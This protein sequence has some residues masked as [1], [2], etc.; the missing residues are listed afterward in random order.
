MENKNKTQNT[1]DYIVIG[2][3]TAGSV[4]A[5]KLTDD[6]KTSLLS[7]EAGDN[8]S[9]ER[10][11]RDSRF[12]PPFI[13]RDNFSPEYYWP[14]KGT[15]QKSV[16]N[17]SFEWTGGRTLGGSS[18]VNNE[19]YVRPTD[20]NIKQW[21]DSLGPLWSPKRKNYLFTK[22]EKYNGGSHNPEARGYQGRLDIRQTPV[23]PT[24]MVEKIIK[25][26]E[27][28]TG[29]KRILD[30]NDPN[31]P[32]G[33]FTRWQ[34]YQMPNGI[35]ESADTAFLT[36]DVVNEDG[37]GVKGR[38]LT[39]SYKSTVRRIIFDEN[40]RARG[41]E[42][43][44]EGRAKVAYARKKVILSAGIKSPELLMLSG[45][46]PE[47]LLKKAKIPLL[48]ANNNVGKHLTTHA[49]NMA[50][51]QV[52]KKDRFRPAKDP[53]ALYVSGAFLPD[54]RKGPESKK[55][56]VQIFG[57]PNDEGNL[58]IGFYLTEPKS[59]GRVSI[60]NNDPLKLVLASEGFLS[61][62]ED[63]ESIK[64]VFK[65]YLRKIAKELSKIDHEY[66][67]L[68]PSFDV[69]QDDKKLEAFIK[70][71][72]Q[73]THHIQGTARMATSP[74]DGVVN[75]KGEVYG[76][77]DLIIADDSIAPFVSDGNTS[78]PAYFIGANIAEILLDQTK[79]KGGKA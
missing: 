78:A 60:Q 38:K 77:H 13:L 8:N 26:M 46:G 45:I 28:A 10:P 3:G 7:I 29:I 40:K 61:H 34:L 79:N 30:Y 55:R 33:P 5:K 71:N 49:A 16:Q 48:V 74:K 2:T 47:K 65:V 1:Y 44:K 39:I 70:E 76:V 17:R 69:I 31:T 58:S 11:I 68:S 35:R 18:S 66:K 41:V 22:L 52:N 15:P 9:K 73:A 6:L 21:E 24:T 64:Q 62:P 63:L 43:V 12:A 53:N 59:K 54:P 23:K 75:G 72:L 32:I 42:Y 50:S 36:R 51:F 4:L 67:L 27:R 14:G 57:Q 19:Q 25:A 37:L 20:L 56:F